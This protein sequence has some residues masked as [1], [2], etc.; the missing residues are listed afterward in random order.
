MTHYVTS[1]IAFTQILYRK[2][3]FT[4]SCLLFCFQTTSKLMTELCRLIML[5]PTETIKSISKVGFTFSYINYYKDSL[6]PF[7]NQAQEDLSDGIVLARI[8]EIISDYQLKKDLT[9]PATLPLQ[10]KH[11]VDLFLRALFRLHICDGTIFDGIFIANSSRLPALHVIWQIMQKIKE[12]LQFSKKIELLLQDLQQSSQIVENQPLISI[13]SETL[14][15]QIQKNSDFFEILNM[16]EHTIK[17]VQQGMNKI[18]SSAAKKDD[19]AISG[20]KKNLDRLQGFWQDSHTTT[21]DR[22]ETLAKVLHLA[23]RFL[24]NHDDILKTVEK[25]TEN[26]KSMEM[27]IELESMKEQTKELKN[28]KAE[29]EKVKVKLREEVIHDGEKMLKFCELQDEKAILKLR[30]NNLAESVGDVYSFCGHKIR[31]HLDLT[32]SVMNFGNDN[33]EHLLAKERVPA[34]E[35]E[36]LQNQLK[37]QRN[38]KNE[39][40]Q[41][42]NNTEDLEKDAEKIK[43]L[44][45]EDHHQAAAAAD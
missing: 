11:N 10:K 44:V 29:I 2:K 37:I 15:E 9:V 27:S 36:Q 23:N 8:V 39:V 1:T 4:E 25:L 42:E 3:M 21:V 34:T 35:P 32:R 41:Q 22:G 26:L 33:T 14:Q 30:M 5:E 31:Q 13:V 38:V 40:D 6:P 19:S 24:A 20:M 18:M 28:I 7:I 43:G 16:Q 12:I 17:A 45:S